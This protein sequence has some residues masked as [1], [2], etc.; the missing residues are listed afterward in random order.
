MT[1]INYEHEFK[2]NESLEEAFKVLR[3]NIHFC[4][5]ENKLKTIAITSYSSGDGKSCVS[6][7][8]SYTIAKSGMKVLFVD[9]DLRKPILYKKLVSKDFKGLSNYLLGNSTL[10]QIINKT[11]IEGFDFVSC[12]IKTLSPGE[13]IASPRLGEFLIKTR[14]IYDFV[15]IDTPPLGSVI[16]GALISSQSDAAIIVVS[17]YKT[18]CNNAIMMKE[19]LQKANANILG[20]VF[21]KVNKLDF[22]NYYGGYDYDNKKTKYSRKLLK[23]IKNVKRDNL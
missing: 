22:R 21:N 15:I 23:E 14:E 1:T 20:V 17:Q 4:D 7:N 19:Q 18:K 3:A 13:L 8:L 12:G 6:A 16:D 11:Q 9:A 5:P 10:E 2:I